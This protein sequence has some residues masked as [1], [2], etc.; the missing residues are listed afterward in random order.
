MMASRCCGGMEAAGQASWYGG[1]V[2]TLERSLGLGPV[3]GISMGAML[4]SGLFVLPGLAVAKTGASVWLAYVVAGICVIPAALSKAELA[5]AMPTS[6]G[7]YVYIDRAFGPLAGTIAGLGL[8]LSLL[9]KSAFA[10]VGFSAY[11]GVI[12]ELPEIPTALA[13]LS[14]V[15]ALNVL[16]V[17]KVGVVQKVV[18][19]IAALA[20][21]GLSA[22]GMAAV[23]P[24]HLDHAFSE[25]MGGFFSAVAFV[26]IS[27]AGVTKVAAIAEEVDRPER[28]LPLGIMISL[29]LAALLYAGVTF[30]MVG[31]VSPEALAGDLKPVHTLALGVGG[32]GA[33]LL[34]A[35]L[36]VVTMTSMANAGVLASSRFPFAMSRDKLLPSFLHQVHVDFLTPVACI[37]LT[38]ALMA[39]AILT[40]DVERI[41]KLAS[42]FKIVIFTVTCMTVIVLRESDARWYRPAWS[43]PMYPWLQGLGILLGLGLLTTLGMTGLAAALGAAVPGALLYA[44]Y[45]RRKVTRRGVLG[46]LG[47]RQE[48]LRSDSQM[49][50]PA[51]ATD[52]VD[53]LPARAAVLVPLLGGERSAETLVEMGAALAEGRAVEVLHITEIPEQTL[54]HAMADDDAIE[55]SLRRRL[56]AM[57]EQHHADIH[58]DTVVTRDAVETVS[59]AV[60]RMGCEWMVMDDRGRTRQ[61]VFQSN[62][63][64]W[65]SQHVPV[66][67]AL[68]HDAGVRYIREILVHVEPG[69]HDALVVGTADHL[70]QL[71]KAR[72]TLA[73]FVP[74]GDDERLEEE[75]AYLE[76]L[77]WL[78]GAPHQV[79]ILRGRK[80][81]TGV[82]RASAAYD[83][84]VIAAAPPT[85]LIER[86][87]GTETQDLVRRAGCSVLQLQTPQRESHA[88]VTRRSERSGPEAF[89]LLDHLDAGSLGVQLPPL[90]REEL[91]RHLAEASAS[92][93]PGVAAERIEAL[94]WE[95]EREQSTAI[96]DGIAM[97]HATIPEL[98]EARLGIYT[99]A[100]P[101][102]YGAPDGQ[103][104]DVLF[105]TLGP[106]GARRTHLLLLSGIARL[107]L[108]TP[109][110]SELRAARTPE[111]LREAIIRCRALVPADAA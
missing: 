92:T 61:G 89:D 77:A 52:M 84:L 4:G 75:T 34:F 104:V 23:Q 13:L 64:G 59:R 43:A 99:L 12:A 50:L 94:L 25:G 96:G 76:E 105:T 91:F 27:Y 51:V 28:N 41:A 66:K 107:A 33:G 35:L 110:L 11:L 46:R 62:P 8:W 49:V 86:M 102:D 14:L 83:L 40:L 47:R 109:L 45:G 5:T 69:P 6:G 15:V 9:L 67:M 90:R 103:P 60:S 39:V 42:A 24:A 95:R 55:E 7:T 20:L 80:M 63:L 56:A 38:A 85:S 30:A 18:V 54:I 100:E 108:S 78:C 48:L 37:L 31:V 10:L 16:G 68:F 73:R 1:P 36:G 72:L 3:V 44:V 17:K 29:G 70:A 2:K 79:R 82:A 111:E 97:P 74:E 88:V 101:M 65:F 57:A 19:A 21:G 22:W 87:L 32:P 106:P 58:F 26:Y 71:E 81:A 93:L 98:T 53:A